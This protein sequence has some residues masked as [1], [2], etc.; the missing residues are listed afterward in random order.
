MSAA[1]KLSDD[2]GEAVRTLTDAA[3]SSGFAMQAF[4]S[5]RS[6]A[7]AEHTMAHLWETADAVRNERL[8][9][10]GILAGAASRIVLCAYQALYA[11]LEDF[12]PD[13]AARFDSY[14]RESPWQ[15]SIEEGLLPFI[16]KVRE[17]MAARTFDRDTLDQRLQA[18][19]TG[20][21]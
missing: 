20:R 14:A 8:D 4:K 7:S 6:A 11:R 10:H 18:F 3:L 2:P 12:E 15:D 21:A 5:S 13:S 19:R 17:E 1:H 16:A 9:L